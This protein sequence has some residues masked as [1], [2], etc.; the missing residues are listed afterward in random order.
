VLRIPDP[1][2]F[3][4]LDPDPGSG[5]ENFK[6]LSEILLSYLWELSALLCVNPLVADGSN[7]IPKFF[8]ADPGFGIFSTLYLGSGMENFGSFWI[9]IPGPQHCSEHWPCLPFSMVFLRELFCTRRLTYCY[10]FA[11]RTPLCWYLFIWVCVSERARVLHPSLTTIVPLGG[12]GVG[13]REGAGQSGS[14][15]KWEHQVRGRGAPIYVFGSKDWMW[16]CF[17][18]LNRQPLGLGIL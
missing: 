14:I 7:H 1:V 12:G 18:V 4:P 9:N 8:V 16:T 2:L 6:V 10:F 13:G 5:M 15:V 3:W 11:L 17:Y